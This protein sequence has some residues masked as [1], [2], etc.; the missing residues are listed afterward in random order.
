MKKNITDTKG[1]A[2]N[3]DFSGWRTKD[4]DLGRVDDTWG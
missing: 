4:I 2:K 3:T 1:K